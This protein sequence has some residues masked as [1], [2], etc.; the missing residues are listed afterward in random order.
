MFLLVLCS[1]RM[2]AMLYICY[3]FMVI[4]KIKKKKCCNLFQISKFANMFLPNS[5]F[6]SNQLLVL[7]YINKILS[8]WFETLKIFPY[9]KFKI[10]C[11]W[12]SKFF[13]CKLYLFYLKANNLFLF[14]NRGDVISTFILGKFANAYITNKYHLG[15]LVSTVHGSLVFSI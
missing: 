3:I 15:L 12:R 9:S 8:Q 2:F 1:N 11:I 13:Y 14:H 10:K 4:I 7:L 6:S 5:S